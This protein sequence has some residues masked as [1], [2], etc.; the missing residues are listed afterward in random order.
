[1]LCL[2]Q[3]L[4]AAADD[5]IAA[6]KAA[7]AADDDDGGGGA[8]AD[9]AAR[10][11]HKLVLKLDFDNKKNLCVRGCNRFSFGRHGSSRNSYRLQNG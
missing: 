6:A 8:G 11:S 5:A 4:W 7:A 9:D 1:M 3:Q 2:D 10:P